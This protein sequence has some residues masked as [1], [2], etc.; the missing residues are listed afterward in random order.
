MVQAMESPYDT[1]NPEV[2]HFPPNPQA[3]VKSHEQVDEEVL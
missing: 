3:A 2:L 1:H